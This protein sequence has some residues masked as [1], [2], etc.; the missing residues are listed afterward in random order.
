MAAHP[1]MRRFV[2]WL[3]SMS[4][5]FIAL[6]LSACLP[7]L[8]LAADEPT[9]VEVKGQYN[10]RRDDTASKTV[11]H[12]AELTR[13]GDTSLLAVLKRLP[14]ITVSGGTVRMRGLGD[15][16]TQI[17]LNGEKAP[18]GFTLDALAPD[19][20][21][22]IEILRSATADTGAQGIAGSIN[23]VMRKA[24]RAPRRDVKLSLGDEG[25]KLTPFL[26]GQSADRAGALSRTFVVA[27]AQ[28]HFDTP[29]LIQEQY[30]LEGLEG[31]VESAQRT[32]GTMDSI[33][34]TPRLN[35]QLGGENSL[36]SQSLLRV[37][38]NTA[39]TDQAVIAA[40]GTAPGFTSSTSRSRTDSQIASTSL[41]WIHRLNPRHLLDTKLGMSYSAKRGGQHFSGIGLGAQP[42]LARD[43]ATRSVDQGLTLR[44][45]DAISLVPGH[46]LVLGWDAAHTR[47]S[48]ERRQSGRGDEDFTVRVGR[49]ALLGQD[50]W[51]V[52]PRW[53]V[54]L[55]GRWEGIA[56]DSVRSGFDTVSSR[57]AVFSPSAQTLYKLAGS[58]G[59]QLRLALARTYK[60]PAAASLNA[61]HI[62]ATL[63][64]STTPDYRG[65]PGLRPELAWGLDF[66]YEYF[67]RDGAMFSA[68]GYVRRI[69]DVTGHSLDKVDGRWVST[70]ANVGSATSQGIE[71]EGKY[72]LGPL[73]LSA[74]LNRN[75]SRVDSLPSPGNR[76]DGQ[77]PLSLNLG[78][79]YAPPGARFS[80]GASFAFQRGGMVR[81]SA[82]ETMSTGAVRTLDAYA[83]YRRDKHLQVRLALSNLLHR[84]A[85]SGSRFEDASGSVNRTQRDRQEASARLTLEYVF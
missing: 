80:G 52:T 13:Y 62:L 36:S 76:L 82:S 74:S 68:G 12:H 37:V 3:P 48:E 64:T 41:N 39:K 77:T 31:S 38:R 32:R 81:T 24:V 1:V 15:G 40:S 27:V 18:P 47:Q 29:S 58:E 53:S 9:V 69:D 55:G 67:A 20:I 75:W 16:Y 44:G 61:R 63:N 11:I 8:A 17:L 85:L 21:D 7:G 10:A 5:R 19:A 70:P 23:I 72:A 45:R 79:D 42:S 30:G 22:R 35:W 2:Y 33:F 60:E 46:T 84:D 6:L 4:H 54:Y 34:F 59:S 28:S 49:L 65:N 66:S 43:T 73:A 14:A 51:N 50:E 26:T 57:S 56:T 71:L 78:A 83:L 25:G